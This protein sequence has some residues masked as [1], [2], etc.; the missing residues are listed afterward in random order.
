MP[1]IH[2]A[3]AEHTDVSAADHKQAGTPVSGQ[4]GNDHK[5][6]LETL[7]KLLDEGGID[8]IDPQTF[9]NE[10]VYASLDEEWQ[11]KVDLSLSNMATQIRL[12]D[13]LRQSGDNDSI[14][15]HTMVEQLWDMKQRIEE[16]HDAFKF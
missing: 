16:H 10:D 12:I 3:I 13:G 1:D 8:P 11:D 7:F 15:L 9:L 14:H 2:D 6:F 5:D 4:V